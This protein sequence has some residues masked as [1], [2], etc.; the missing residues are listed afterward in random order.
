MISIRR[1]N[2]NDRASI[3]K[4][5]AQCF[6]HDDPI[7][8][9][10]DTDLIWIGVDSETDKPACFAHVEEW[11]ASEETALC[12]QRMGVAQA[13]RGNGLQARMLQVVA[14]QARR[15]SKDELWA[16]TT[17]VNTHSMNNF[18]RAGFVTWRP[19][20][21]ARLYVGPYDPRYVYWRKDVRR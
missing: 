15:M 18:I 8:L 16:L 13:F 17:N 3:L 6:K 10:F 9:S 12:I 19:G 2:E 20:S 1:A 14:S 21:W 7:K 4:L 5:N 11:H